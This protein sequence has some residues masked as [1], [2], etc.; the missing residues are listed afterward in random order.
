MLAL[1]SGFTCI[2]MFWLTIRRSGFG[3]TYSRCTYLVMW[4]EY[5]QILEPGTFPT[6]DFLPPHLRL[7]Q[8]SYLDIP[9]TEIALPP[10]ID[11]SVADRDQVRN[12]EDAMPFSQR[13]DLHVQFGPFRSQ[14]IVMAG[15]A[16][17]RYVRRRLGISPQDRE[18]LKADEANR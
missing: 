16:N 6:N 11:V 14:T 17:E 13:S 1:W 4:G 18:R 9:E 7:D 8:R 5:K 12:L 15:G 2:A 10:I 3:T